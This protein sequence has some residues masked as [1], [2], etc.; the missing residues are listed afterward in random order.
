MH[1]LVTGGRGFIGSYVCEELSARGHVP[2]IFDRRSDSSSREQL[3]ATM[4]GDVRDSTA[5]TE[6]VAHADAVIH[7]AGVLGTQETISNPRPA[8]ETNVLGGLNVLQACAE[9]STPL[10]NI[11]VG[12][13]F[14]HNTYSITKHAVERFASMFTRYRGLP[15]CS[16]RAFNVYG[17]GQSVAQ[18]YGP[19]RVRKILPSFIMRAL[20]GQPVE[21]YG[22]GSQIMDMIYAPDAA[23]VLAAAL[24]HVADGIGA[25]ATWQAGTGRPTTVLQIAQTVCAEVE[26]QTGARPKIEHL[27]MRPGETPGVE[28]CADVEQLDELQVLD[29]WRGQ[30]T[31]LE[32]GVAAT[33]KH[34]VGMLS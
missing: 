17:P 26:R 9:Y 13:W 3:G 19:S 5:V 14:E 20:T 10:V 32:D 6:A 11:A 8:A 29:V 16:V 31:S 28:V 24:E 1:V 33:V 15:A 34:Y 25:G 27:P 4:L 7:L 30:F 12:N 22:D 2:V 23:R 21:V 18:P